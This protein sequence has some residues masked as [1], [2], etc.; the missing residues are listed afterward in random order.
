MSTIQIELWCPNCGS[1]EVLSKYNEKEN[2]IVC[3]CKK[4]NYTVS[5]GEFD[6]LIK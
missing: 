1:D 6:Y 4:C 2:I 5:L 3:I